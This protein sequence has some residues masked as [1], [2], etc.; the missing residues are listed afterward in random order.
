MTSAV[1]DLVAQS[2]VI[3]D[4]EITAI[5]AAANT[6]MAPYDSTPIQLVVSSV[7]ID[8]DGNGVVQWSDASENATP[9]G[10]CS[11]MTLPAAFQVSGTYLVVVEGKYS[12][13]PLIGYIVDEEIQFEDVFYLR[14]RLSAQVER[15]PPPSNAC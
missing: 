12:Y 11:D 5:F 3:S 1:G 14:P 2:S 10:T 4:Q 15:D 13:T 9:R 6:M 8:D 7:L